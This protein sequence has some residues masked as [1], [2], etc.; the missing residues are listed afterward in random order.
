M[1]VRARHALL[2]A[3]WRGGLHV[4]TDV[5]LPAIG[6]LRRD[7]SAE[8][9]NKQRRESASHD[10]VQRRSLPRSHENGIGQW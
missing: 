2:T 10:F 7:D 3:D 5:Q 1:H 6:A 4:I 8:E 9:G